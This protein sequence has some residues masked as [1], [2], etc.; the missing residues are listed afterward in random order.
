MTLR[1]LRA[2]RIKRF[3]EQF[4]DAIDI[5]VRSLKAGHPLPIAINLVA[6][7]MPDPI[8]TEFG[9]VGDELSFGLDLETAHS[10]TLHRQ[11]N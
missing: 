7:E 2:R 8:G 1:F 10:V 9:M 4:A 3:A 6:R 5:I 11:S